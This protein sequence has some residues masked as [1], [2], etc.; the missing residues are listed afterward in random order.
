M[1][2]PFSTLYYYIVNKEKQRKKLDSTVSI[3]LPL[4]W[5]L[6]TAALPADCLLTRYSSPSR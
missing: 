2:L 5:Q 6:L 3:K 1:M 4:L